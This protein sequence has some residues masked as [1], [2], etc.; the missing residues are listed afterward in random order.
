MS[1]VSSTADMQASQMEAK[2]LKNP[3]LWQIHVTGTTSHHILQL[4]KLP[5]YY[6][7]ASPMNWNKGIVQISSFQNCVQENPG[8]LC[9]V[10]GL[11]IAAGP[12]A[13]TLGVFPNKG[14]S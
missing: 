12:A 3:V 2:G 14:S 11:T 4:G 6:Q 5:K 1:Q 10:Q 9:M 7:S 13:L 8:P